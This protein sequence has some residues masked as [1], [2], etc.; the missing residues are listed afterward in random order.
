VR[1]A[2]EGADLSAVEFPPL[3]GEIENCL[4]LV[5]AGRF[6]EAMQATKPLFLR[7]Q[8]EGADALAAEALDL[9]GWCCLRLGEMAAGLDCSTA[10]R[11]IW[12]RLGQPSRA[13]TSRAL[14]AMQ[15]LDMG[16][17]DEAFDTADLALVETAGDP[18]AEI[19]A[20]HAKAV[21][22]AV[23]REPQLARP[24]LEQCVAAAK[25]RDAWQMLDLYL[26][27]LAYCYSALAG[28]ALLRG[29]DAA[30]RAL[31]ADAIAVNAEAIEV[32]GAHGNIWVLRCC[33]HNGAEYL[34]E[35]GRGREGLRHLERAA[36]DDIDTGLLQ[37][38][39][40]LY[41]LGATRRSIGD[42][43][44]A[45]HACEEALLLA[46]E[47]DHVDHQVNALAQLCDVESALGSF[48]AALAAHRRF[49][50]AYVRQSGET[51]QRRARVAAIRF[52]SERWQAE[53][54]QLAGEVRRDALTGIGNRRAF[55]E[56]T[57]A[58]GGRPHCVAIL[59]LDLFK[60]VNDR[61]S[62]LVGDTVLKRVADILTQCMA[63]AGVA[64]R[65]GGEEFGLLFHSAGFDAARSACEEIR[66]RVAD[67][68]WS[69]VAPGLSVTCS[70]GVAVAEG[71]AEAE[72][73]LAVADRRL[74]AAKLAG[75]NRTVADDDAAALS[76]A[77]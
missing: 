55:D 21:I 77:V 49:H 64:A 54:S 20:R 74:Y 13:G 35:Q 73:A 22:L 63:D 32:A 24:M 72:Q 65:L 61:F 42:L 40:Y 60:A 1:E 69:V 7:A 23:S 43:L 14:E 51:A 10:A 39:H 34:A 75:R 47:V 37:R 31:R 38:I 59:D 52:E 29:D 57:E 45:K 56:A 66:R 4:S 68:D 8:A 5:R 36:A 2:V 28:D 53:A 46:E 30:A 58:F 76:L 19:F 15:L 9:L 11:R 67:T 27:D 6:P 17:T 16:L 3:A 18:E 50:A 26:L 44:G 25:A 62:H 33:L 71:Y 70:I 48:E 12:M 41:S